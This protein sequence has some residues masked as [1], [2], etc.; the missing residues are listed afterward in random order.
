MPG[1][2]PQG[3]PTP[4]PQGYFPMD[5]SSSLY[6]SIENYQGTIYPSQM[7]NPDA[8]CHALN[9]AMK[10]LGK[11][12]KDLLSKDHLICCTIFKNN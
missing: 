10:G 5:Q 8:D 6:A 1:T 9:H 7:F 12:E 4:G 3:M 2:Y 11:F